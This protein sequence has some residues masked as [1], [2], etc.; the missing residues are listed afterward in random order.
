MRHRAPVRQPQVPERADLDR[1][2]G[3]A[4]LDGG[5]EAALPARSESGLTRRCG[6]L[7]HRGRVAAAGA[8]QHLLYC[9]M[10]ERNSVLGQ[11]FSDG[12]EGEAVVT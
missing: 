11:R 8:P 6:R 7:F 10:R 1:K 3:A 2:S 4:V 5:V 9:H 12:A